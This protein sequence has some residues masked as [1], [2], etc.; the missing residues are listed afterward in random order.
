MFYTWAKQVSARALSRV[1]LAFA[2]AYPCIATYTNSK[3]LP[4]YH[5]LH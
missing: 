1:N 5:Y 4:M 2:D 3:L